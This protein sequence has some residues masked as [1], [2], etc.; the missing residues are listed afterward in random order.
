MATPTNLP[1]AVATGDIG[2]AAQF[3]NLRGAFRILQVVIG[4][5]TVQVASTSATYV[6]TGL[7]ATITPQATSSQI[8]VCVSQSCYTQGTGTAIGL[9]LR[10]GSTTIRTDQDLCFG[11]NSGV[12]AQ[13]TFFHLDSPASTGA[14]TYSTQFN[15]TIGGSTVFVQTNGANNTSNIVLLEVSA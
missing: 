13:Q 5:A 9:L 14:L 11:T 15:R 3:N 4:T 6:N 2:T 10:R 7:S 1:A 8:L 12:L